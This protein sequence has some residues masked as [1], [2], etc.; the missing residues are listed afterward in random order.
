[1]SHSVIEGIWYGDSRLAGLVRAALTPAARAYAGV[2]AVRNALYDRGLLHAHSPVVP[3]LSLGNLSVG[4][5]GKTPL[6]AW[7]AGELRARGAHPSIVL[8]GYGDDEPIV[9][10]RLNPDV[11]VVADADRVRG[12]RRARALGADCAILDD[13]FQHRRIRR[14]ADWVLVAAERWQA[15]ARSLP[16][17]PMRESTQSLHRAHVLVITRKSASREEAERVASALEPR[18][19]DG[20][21]VAICHLAAHAVV[22]AIAG[23]EERL[24]WLEGRTFAAPAAVGAPEAFFAQLRAAGAVIEPMPFPDHHA[25]D[26]RDVERIVQA[27]ASRDGVICTL[28]DAVKLAPRWPRAGPALWYVSQRAVIERGGEALDASLNQ[29]LAARTTDP[30]TAGLAGPSSPAHGHRSSTA[31]R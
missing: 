14:T 29:L 30:Q 19:R 28:K 4:G 8:R 27:G 12:V 31:D 25:F 20:G 24:S 7:A 10:A 15:T 21:A 16:A 11:P 2:T 3:V 1:M 17:G 26:A 22:D 18:M 13:G 23:R 9:H 6:A 5:T